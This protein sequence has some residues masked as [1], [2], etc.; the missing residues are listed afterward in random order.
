MTSPTTPTVPDTRIQRAGCAMGGA[1][2]TLTLTCT[3]VPAARE[4]FQRLTRAVDAGELATLLRSAE[5]S[6]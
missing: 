5:V 3:T 2:V 6:P 4:L 1:T